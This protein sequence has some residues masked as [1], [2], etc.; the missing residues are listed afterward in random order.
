MLTLVVDYEGKDTALML[1]IW[2][3]LNQAVPHIKR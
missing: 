1:V 3:L 2:V